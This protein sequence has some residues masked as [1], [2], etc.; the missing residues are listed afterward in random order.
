MHER[1]STE[2]NPD[3]ESASVKWFPV[4]SKEY[5]ATGTKSVVSESNDNGVDESFEIMHDSDTSPLAATTLPENKILSGDTA[6]INQYESIDDSE[7]FN[8][9]VTNG[10]KT[11][12]YSSVNNDPLNEN[13]TQDEVEGGNNTQLSKSTI[14]GKFN[15]TLA[16]NSSTTRGLDF[17]NFAVS[18]SRNLKT[19]GN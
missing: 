4:Q 5:A 14:G 12:N 6:F 2:V 18:R 3:D 15:D 9:L 8:Y 10:N 1:G 11:D 13:T 16:A 19:S 7:K 17:I